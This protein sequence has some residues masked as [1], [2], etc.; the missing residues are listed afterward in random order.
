MD[1]RWKELARLLVGYSAPVHTGEK[2]MI[3]MTEPESYPLVAALYEE[4]VRAGGYPQVQ[5]LSEELNRALLKHGTREQIE[6]VPEVEAFGMEWANVYF[7]LR[8]AHNP[9]VFWDLP[10]DRLS[11]LR[12]SMGRISS[13]R[14]EKTRWCLLRLP[15]PALA[16]QAGVDEETMMD[17]FFDACLL[18]WPEA[19]REWARWTEILAR[20]KEIHVVGKDT[21]LRFS[22]AGRGWDVAAGRINM[23]DGEIATSPV[24][25]TVNG[26][27]AFEN[28]AV[29][30]GRLIEG[31]FLR[32]EAGALKETRSTTN[33]DFFERIVTTDSG[34]GMVGE[35]AFGTNPHVRFFSNDILLDEKIAGTVHLAL[36]RAY[37]GTGGT[38][39][40]AIHW[41]IVKDLRT[42]GQVYL[43]GALIFDK[44][45]MLL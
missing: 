17:M 15:G 32:W 25:S 5:F 28:P 36:G 29:I 8:G 37:P 24:E 19:G 11:W 22:I 16:Q 38:V 18:D 9:S 41:D 3:A 2:V 6:W 7:G 44:G 13:L 43:D 12:R 27:I 40:S 4:C 34:S 14:W 30:G 1:R 45:R 39:K 10:A 31:L 42:Q 23:P 26:H 20:G 33:Q 35:F 21:D